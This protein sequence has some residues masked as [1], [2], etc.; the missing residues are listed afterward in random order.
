MTISGT[1]LPDKQLPCLLVLEF[2]PRMYL[3]FIESDN[4]SCMQT[5][6]APQTSLAQSQANSLPNNVTGTKPPQ[7][8]T[9]FKLP[10]NNSPQPPTQINP[11][12]E[13]HLKAIE[14]FSGMCSIRAFW[15]VAR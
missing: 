7:Q 9:R 14:N 3:S 4:I 12:E 6:V 15:S 1:L 11:V 10:P 13:F 5:N 2:Q 8:R